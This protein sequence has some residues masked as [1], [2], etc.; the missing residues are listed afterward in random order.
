MNS[1]IVLYHIIY[2]RSQL[3]KVTLQFNVQ[4]S[5]QYRKIYSEPLSRLNITQLDLEPQVSALCLALHELHLET[6][7]R[8]NYRHAPL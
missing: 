4:I 2:F 1:C 5:K 8:V 3:Y 7:T 6:E